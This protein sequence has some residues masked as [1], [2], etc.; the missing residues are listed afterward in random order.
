MLCLQGKVKSGDIDN[1]TSLN[2]SGYI[3]S[4]RLMS[5]LDVI[6]DFTR[7]L[8]LDELSEKAINFVN[9]NGAKLLVIDSL[10]NIYV[11]NGDRSSCIPFLKD[12]AIT[13]NV[14]ILLTCGL[15]KDLEERDNKHPCLTDLDNYRV[16]DDNADSILFLYRESMY[17]ETCEDDDSVMVEMDKTRSG[18]LGA[19]MLMFNKDYLR[20]G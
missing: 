14:P 4:K 13:L 2:N 5:D 3:E 10:D 18:V 7:K 9:D 17:D 8:T 12:L 20:L 15:N 19:S 1:M 6:V 16:Y 11:G